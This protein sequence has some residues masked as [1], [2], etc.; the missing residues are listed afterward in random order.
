[1]ERRDIPSIAARKDGSSDAMPINCSSWINDG[2]REELNPSCPL[3]LQVL[4]A[5]QLADDAR[6]YPADII[7]DLL[8]QRVLVRL[9]L[10]A[11]DALAALAA[12]GGDAIGFQR[13]VM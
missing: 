11:R 13:R 3:I 6:L 12:H 1:M 10:F 5:Q 2:F 9:I 8:A 7:D 4:N